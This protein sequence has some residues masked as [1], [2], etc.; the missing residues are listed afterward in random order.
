MAITR[1]AIVD[2]ALA[3]AEQTSWEALRLHDVATALSGDLNDVRAYFREKEEIV[4]AWLD[5]ADRAMLADAARLDEYRALTPRQRIERALMAW[6][7]ALAPYRRVTRQMIL[8]KLEPGHL[9]YQWSGLLRVSRTV[10]WLREAAMRDATLPWRAV[11]ETALTG[12]FLAT[13]FC[14]MYDDSLDSVRTRAFLSRRL[15][16]V[17]RLARAVGCFRDPAASRRY[18]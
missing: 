1:D 17:E 11:E 18:S 12:I 14:W 15:D 2:A 8:N 3:R 7:G 13:F 9:H 10:Q 16:R 4:D 5:R 6:F